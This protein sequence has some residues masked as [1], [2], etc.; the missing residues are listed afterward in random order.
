MSTDTPNGVYAAF[1][2]AMNE[3]GAVGKD[4]RNEQGWMFRGIDAVMNAV[5]P[6]FR[7]HGLFI[8]PEV[9]DHNLVATPRGTKT[10][11]ISVI[12]KVRYSVVHSDGSSFSGVV[13]GEGNDFSDKATAKSLS[14][15]LRTFLIQSLVLPTHDEDPDAVSI[16]RGSPQAAPARVTVPDDWR[17]YVETAESAG[18]LATLQMMLKQAN[19]AGHQEAYNGIAESIDRTKAAA[20]PPAA[21]PPLPK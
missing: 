4:S 12:V 20:T 6:A 15:A 21:T 19:D 11:V 16:E 3:I 10:P 9:L 5:G 2:A 7:K 18:D 17:N 1:T 13:M 8:L 14:V